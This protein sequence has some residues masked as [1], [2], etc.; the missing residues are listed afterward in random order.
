MTPIPLIC[1]EEETVLNVSEK[2]AQ[3]GLQISSRWTGRPEAV[4]A[5]HLTTQVFVTQIIAPK[6]TG[7]KLRTTR[8]K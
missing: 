2:L 4:E 3:N 7:K 8:K 5:K 6:I 1:D